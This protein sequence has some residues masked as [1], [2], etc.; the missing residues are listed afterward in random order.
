MH[1]AVVLVMEETN[2]VGSALSAASPHRDWVLASARDLEGTREEL[3]AANPAFLIVEYRPRFLEALAWVLEHRPEVR[4]V[5]LLEGQPRQLGHELMGLGVWLW[6]V[7]DEWLR[8]LPRLLDFMAANH[9][10]PTRG[11]SR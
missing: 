3:R 6:L 1:A 5:V 9:A 7:E 10:R 4:V 2:R 11:G 8:L